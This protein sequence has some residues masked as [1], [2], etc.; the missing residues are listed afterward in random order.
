[1][2]NV[3]KWDD[4]NLWG[5]LMATRR[6][7]IE[8]HIPDTIDTPSEEAFRAVLRAAFVAD[9][10][11]RAQFHGWDTDKARAEALKVEVK[12]R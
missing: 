2:T 8:V 10:L 6:V 7:T 4:G 3:S 1:M 12:V 5:T 11:A 9:A